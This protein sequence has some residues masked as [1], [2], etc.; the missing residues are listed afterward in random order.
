MTE[1]AASEIPTAAFIS[2]D[3][4]KFGRTTFNIPS[5]ISGERGMVR[6]FPF[7]RRGQWSIQDLKEGYPALSKCSV[8]VVAMDSTET[9]WVRGLRESDVR[10]QSVLYLT[11]LEDSMEV[12]ERVKK[13]HPTAT[14]KCVLDDEIEMQMTHLIDIFVTKG[15]IPQISGG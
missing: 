4:I 7:T 6:V 9:H 12:E 8:V 11:E 3:A 14:I 2:A 15:K 5:T 10:A 13:D 1:N